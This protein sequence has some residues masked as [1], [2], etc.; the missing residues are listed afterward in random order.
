MKIISLGGWALG[1][2]QEPARCDTVRLG[3]VS[4]NNAERRRQDRRIICEAEARYDIWDRID[5][6]H[7][8]SE[9]RKQNHFDFHRRLRIDGAIIG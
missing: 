8:I 4:A 6:E 7:K 3:N 5:R 9:R 2:T 1:Q